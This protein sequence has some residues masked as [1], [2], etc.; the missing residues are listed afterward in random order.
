MPRDPLFLVAVHAF[1][2]RD[3][4]LLMAQR[5]NTG[6][7]DG[8]FSVPA[9][10]V[11][12]G[13]GIFEAIRREVEEEAGIVLSDLPDPVHVMR[14]IKLN[15][16]RVDYFFVIEEWEGEPTNTEPEKCTKFSWFSLEDLPE[17]TV[18]YIREAVGHI[19]AKK[20]FSDF[21]DL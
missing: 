5:Q 10:H 4:Q 18:P 16:E 6:Y 8:F 17:N 13:E 9:G 11:E 15:D 20:R 2:I 19:L 3:G 7:M 12:A 1:F 21:H 14:R